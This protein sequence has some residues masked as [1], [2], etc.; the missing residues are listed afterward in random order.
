MAASS[1]AVDTHDKLKVYRRNQVQEDLIWQVY[2][3]ELDWFILED[4]EY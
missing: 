4:G 2:D 1:T 3:G